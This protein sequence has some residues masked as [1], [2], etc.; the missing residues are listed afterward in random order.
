MCENSTKTAPENDSQYVLQFPKAAYYVLC[1]RSDRGL[2]LSQI[3][4]LFHI[5][6]AHD[7]SSEFE[8][9]DNIC[10]SHNM[11]SVHWH[12]YCDYH[13]THHITSSSN[14]VHT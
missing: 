12:H 6:S 13:K 14:S 10:S 8:G 9:I 2:A 11:S 3:R 1:E 4:S 5:L 7:H